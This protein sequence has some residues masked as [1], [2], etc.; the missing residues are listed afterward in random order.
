VYRGRFLAAYVALIVLAGV[1]V[2]AAITVWTRPE[3]KPPP[4]WSTWKPE[5]S[6][7]LQKVRSIASHV[8]ASYTKPPSDPLVQVRGGP[9][10]LGG[11]ELLL[12][13]RPD[14]KA[15]SVD[16]VDGATVEYSLCGTAE[17]CAVKGVPQGQVGVLT[18]REALELALYTFK[19]VPNVQNVVVFM[20]PV[21][22]KERTRVVLIRRKE[23]TKLLNTPL[24]LPGHRDKTTTRDA[25]SIALAT[26]PYVYH[27][28]LATVGEQS[29]P[30]LVVNPM[31]IAA[32]SK[33]HAGASAIKNPG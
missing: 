30:A 24:A 8:G 14:T 28:E 20:P 27:F 13:T 5:G 31:N 12:A 16:I 3:P 1:G 18:R 4:I 11:Q 32:T 23:V 2:G 29:T 17:N 21:F 7:Q 26:D 22:E 15:Q 10:V 6:T 33:A 19:Y 25:E 9:L